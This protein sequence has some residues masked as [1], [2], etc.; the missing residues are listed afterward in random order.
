MARLNRIESIDEKNAKKLKTVGIT[1]VESLLDAGATAAKRKT[2]A[3]DAKVNEKQ[4]LRWV[5]HADLF[6]IK[7]VA[8]LKAELL[9]GIG[10]SNI[11]Q[12]GK[13]DPVK[14]REEMLSYNDKKNLVQRV[15]G[16]IQVKRWVQTAKKM[17][18]VVK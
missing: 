7:G 3:K 10:V 8:G 4:L 12:L 17:K 6:R 11:N 15:P 9:E 2:L 18:P 5:K 13:K 1:T 16:M 14:L